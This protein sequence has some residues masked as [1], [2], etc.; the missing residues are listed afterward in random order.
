MQPT[1]RIKYAILNQLQTLAICTVTIMG[2]INMSYFITV[3]D[4]SNTFQIAML[5]QPNIGKWSA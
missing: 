5:P 2:D 1:L 4:D 3:G